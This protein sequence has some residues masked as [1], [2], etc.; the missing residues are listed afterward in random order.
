MTTIFYIRNRTQ[1][2]IAMVWGHSELHLWAS[3]L[4]FVCITLVEM[5]QYCSVSK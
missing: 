3:L 5:L 4:Q 2:V 1:L